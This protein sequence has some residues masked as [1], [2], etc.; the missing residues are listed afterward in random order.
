MK[1]SSS[2]FCVMYIFFKSSL[3]LQFTVVY[4]VWCEGKLCK[5]PK[6]CSLQGARKVP[7]I[8]PGSFPEPPSAQT[9]DKQPLGSSCASARS[10]PM[11]STW[12]LMGTGS[13]MLWLIAT[14]WLGLFPKWHRRVTF[15]GEWLNQM[16]WLRINTRGG[17][18]N[19]DY[20][21]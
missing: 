2:I 7:R 15:G 9:Y 10:V 12:L 3:H 21:L 11:Q 16:H 6:H 8:T 18:Q 1:W 4:V 19:I 14:S 5:K 17:A 13:A 20:R